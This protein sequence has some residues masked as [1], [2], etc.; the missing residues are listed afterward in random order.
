[1]PNADVSDEAFCQM[2]VPVDT[3]GQ[4]VGVTT[5][6]EG[7][8]WIEVDAVTVVEVLLDFTLEVPRELD[9]DDPLQD[10]EDD[11]QVVDFTEVLDVACEDLVLVDLSCELE[12]ELDDFLDVLL[13]LLEEELGTEVALLLG[14]P[15]VGVGF[16][17]RI[18][19]EVP[20]GFDGD[21]GLL[22]DLAETRLEVEDVFLDDE[23]LLVLL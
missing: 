19:D 14:V 18:D 13:D 20:D 9:G 4:L 12:G 23:K 15:I 16:L 22:S 7:D 8:P 3:H 6:I 5:V 21:K 10:D 2:S 17:L 11:F 1:M